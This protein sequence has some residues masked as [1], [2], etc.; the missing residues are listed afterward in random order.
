MG[1]GIVFRGERPFN[2]IFSIRPSGRLRRVAVF[3]GRPDTARLG[4][5]ALVASPR[6]QLTVTADR[7]TSANAAAE[8]VY[9]GP[10]G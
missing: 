6:Q 10:R 5:T 3:S 4:S 7:N 1:Q 8:E 9:D 2:V